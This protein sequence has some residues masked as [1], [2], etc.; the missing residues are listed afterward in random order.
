M[1][2][3]I[4]TDKHDFSY[5]LYFVLDLQDL[6]YFRRPP[7]PSSDLGHARQAAALLGIVEWKQEK[8]TRRSFMLFLLFSNMVP[9]D[10]CSL[11]AQILTISAPYG[12]KF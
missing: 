6:S 7:C 3:I 1:A 10:L 11:W 9:A 12:H 8:R 4:I 2:I 5:K